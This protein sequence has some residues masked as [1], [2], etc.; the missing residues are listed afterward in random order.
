MNHISLKDIIN[1]FNLVPITEVGDSKKIKITSVNVNRPGIH[2]L[3]F[4]DTFDTKR[5]QVFGE[6]EM[7]FLATLSQPKRKEVFEKFFSY[8][9]PCVIV[10]RDIEPFPEML[11]SSIKSN[12]PILRAVQDTSS[13]T[14]ALVRYLNYQLAPKTSIHGVLVEVYG[15]G[16]LITGESGIGKSETALELIKR[17]HGFISDD[18]VKIKKISYNNL[19]GE[20]PDLIRHFI[21]IRGLGLIDVGHIFGMGAIKD[22]YSINMVINLENWDGK[23]SYDRLGIDEDSIDILGIKVPC[24]TIPVKPGRNLAVIIEVAAMNFRQKSMGYNAAKVLNERLSNE[25]KNKAK[26]TQE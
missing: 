2:L 22:S 8:S 6:G 14:T 7:T 10:A 9:V 13:L 12:I 23:K 18:V 25:I 1:E 26:D 19:I 16:I 5:I 15:Q 20:P 3:G 17:G 24:V 11:E 21:E 4:F